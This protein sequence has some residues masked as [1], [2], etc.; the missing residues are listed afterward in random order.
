MK[1]LTAHALPV[2]PG[3]A[4][5]GA[6]ITV[7]AVGAVIYAGPKVMLSAALVGGGLFAIA[8]ANVVATGACDLTMTGVRMAKARW[9][10]HKAREPKPDVRGGAVAQTAVAGT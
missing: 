9:A 2:S 10:E 3:V 8:T 7:A 6:A 4:L 1:M 5:A